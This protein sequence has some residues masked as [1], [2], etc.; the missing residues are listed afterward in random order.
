MTQRTD[1]RITLQT[2]D[3]EVRLPTQSVDTVK[4]SPLSMMPEGLLDK[5]DNS[6]IRDLI[7]W[8]MSDGMLPR[9][10]AKP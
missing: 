6:Q 10:P 5:L 2:V 9:Q 4:T 8:L 7:A 1:A 3:G